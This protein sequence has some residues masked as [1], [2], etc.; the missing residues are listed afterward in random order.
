MTSEQLIP[1]KPDQTTDVTERSATAFSLAELLDFLAI[2][3]EAKP[4][5]YIETLLGFLSIIHGFDIPIEQN[6][7][8]LELF[9]LRIEEEVKA[10]E[11]TLLKHQNKLPLSHRVQQEVI[12]INDALEMLAQEY[13]YGLSELFDPLK[14]AP[15]RA[16]GAILGRA[17]HALNTRII[18]QFRSGS[19]PSPGSWQQLNN[20]F[21]SALRF[22][23]Q[24]ENSGGNTPTI[25]QMVSKTLL[26]AISQ[27]SAFSG[28]ELEFISSYLDLK[29][30]SLEFS[31][32]PTSPTES[33]FWIEPGRDAPPQPLTRRLP[34]PDGSPL[35]FSCQNI[36]QSALEDLNKL[37]Q[38]GSLDI[39]NSLDTRLCKSLLKKLASRWGKPSRRRFPRRRQ[40]YRVNLC[41]GSH[42]I[43]NALL[44]ALSEDDLTSEWMVTNESANGFSLMHVTGVLHQIQT[45]EI[46]SLERVSDTHIRAPKQFCIVRWVTSDNPEHVE[47]GVQTLCPTLYPASIFQHTTGEHFH[48]PIPALFLPQHHTLRATDGILIDHKHLP[49]S[50]AKVLILIEK[51]NIELRE[52]QLDTSEEQTDKLEI[53]TLQTLV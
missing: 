23:L 36:A 32:T 16:P 24:K 41:A 6:V 20:S 31:N 5:R 1:A 46:V 47:I 45:G 44:I 27:P 25:N 43:R 51:N 30:P 18:L 22:N 52:V 15:S 34:H 9:Q 19:T 42:A 8:I 13:L 4:P 40:S 10:L 53:F 28:I 12:P 3:S 21:F 17:I 14:T 38:G 48:P 35:Y 29:A 33:I 7:Q 50:E 26:L 37:Q 49:L 39:A 2:P 11:F